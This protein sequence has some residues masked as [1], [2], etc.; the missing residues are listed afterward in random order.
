M[1]I[2][3]LEWDDEKARINLLKHHVSFETAQYIFSDGDRLER[4]DR[5]ENNATGEARWQTI[6]KVGDTLFVVYAETDAAKRLI[7][8]RKAN[9]A[10]RRSYNGYYQI[11]GQGWAKAE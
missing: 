2:E 3:G 5:S 9:K 6:G 4:F 10:E 7:S 11:D 8:A 1:P